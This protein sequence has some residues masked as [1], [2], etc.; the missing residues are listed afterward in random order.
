MRLTAE[1]NPEAVKRYLHLKAV[2]AWRGARCGVGCSGARQT[3]TLSPGHSGPH[4]AHGR[5]NRILAVW[6]GSG[7]TAP[8]ASK[9][10]R[11]TQP[12]SRRRRQPGGPVQALSGFVARVMRRPAHY[13][14][15]ALLLIFFLFMVGF[16]IDWTLRIMGWK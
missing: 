1:D 12:P 4:V 2:P 11:A 16:V 14:E 10:I 13:S 7:V 6:D 3:C 8:P 15:E 5:F 9:P